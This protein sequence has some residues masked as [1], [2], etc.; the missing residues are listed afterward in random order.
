MS[1]RWSLLVLLLAPVLAPVYGEASTGAGTPFRAVIRTA[2]ATHTQE[3]FRSRGPQLLRVVEAEVRSCGRGGMHG[4][5]RSPVLLVISPI[6]GNR[7][8][9]PVDGLR[10]FSERLPYHATAPPAGR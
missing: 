7:A 5:L 2:S 6:P 10:P 4:S 1:L 8:R 9:R 3:V